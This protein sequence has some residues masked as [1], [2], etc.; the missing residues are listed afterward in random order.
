M[1]V[2]SS[3]AQTISVNRSRSDPGGTDSGQ[4]LHQE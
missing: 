3:S 4:F 2:A 1:T